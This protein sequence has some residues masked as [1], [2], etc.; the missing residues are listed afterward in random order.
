MLLSQI[1]NGENAYNR[2]PLMLPQKHSLFLL[3]V[4]W[5]I[6]LVDDL[7]PLLKLNRFIFKVIK[8]KN[9]KA[10]YIKEQSPAHSQEKAARDSVKM[11]Q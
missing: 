1:I 7:G 3:F 6:T 8:S 11:G 2:N 5:I 10:Y 9:F 4:G